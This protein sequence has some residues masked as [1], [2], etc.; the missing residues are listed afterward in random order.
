MRD[1]FIADRIRHDAASR[2]AIAAHVQ[3]TK[4]CAVQ[5]PATRVAPPG[6]NFSQYIDGGDVFALVPL[7]VK[8]CSYNFTGPE[9]FPYESVIVCAVKQHEGQEQPPRVYYRCSADLS[10]VIEIPSA[11]REQW[12]IREIE[13]RSYPGGPTAERCYFAPFEFVT[14]AKL[15]APP[16]PYEEKD[17]P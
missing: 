17:T 13:N 9:D 4:G 2:H 14:F 5:V 11:F 15:E 7:A 16:N 6:S 1:D 10:H 8:Q 12:E 3:A